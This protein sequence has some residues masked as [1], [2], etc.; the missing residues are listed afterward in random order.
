MADDLRETQV[1]EEEVLKEED[2]EEEKGEEEEDE[3]ESDDEVSE[4]EPSS[5]DSYDHGHDNSDDEN[6]RYIENGYMPDFSIDEKDDEHDY[7]N[8]DVRFEPSFE[9]ACR[10]G[11]PLSVIR[12]IVDRKRRRDPDFLVRPLT[13]D[14]EIPLHIAAKRRA[15]IDM[16][17]YLVQLNPR[18]AR[19]ARRCPRFTSP[20]FTIVRRT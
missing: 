9:S 18:R 10:Q 5:S 2:N 17:R 11:V 12:S 13:W 14:K 19:L 1:Q 20:L 16:I 7:R 6:I 4:K 8:S 3:T 15:P